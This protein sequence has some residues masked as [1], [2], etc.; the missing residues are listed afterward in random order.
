MSD[1]RVEIP[2]VLHGGGLELGPYATRFPLEERTILHV[3]RAQAAEYGEK[4]W[5]V[6]DGQD[7]LTFAEAQRLTNRI[8]HAIRDSVGANAHVGLYLRNQYEF[9]PAEMGAMA[10]PGVAVPL[11]ADARGPLLR[12]QIERADIALMVSRVDLLPWLENLEGLGETKLVVA[13][14]EGELPSRVAGVEVV[15]WDDWLAGK[16]ETAPAELPRYDDMGVIAF[17]SGT[18]GRA[19]G[20]VHTHHYWQLFS[21]IVTDSLERTPDD[22]LTSPLPL[23]HGGALH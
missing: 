23:Y 15:R 3:L 1:V 9:M 18:T 17:T 16:P 4:P 7:T 11:N 22:V 20:V 6:F 14:G 13:V 19:K 10:A 21:A 12:S 5:L 8:A 2:R